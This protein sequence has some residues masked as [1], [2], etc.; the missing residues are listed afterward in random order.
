MTKPLKIQ[1][2]DT[3][4]KQ[5]GDHVPWESDKPL[6][7]LLK[8]V[9]SGLVKGKDALDIGCGTGNQSIYLAQQGFKVTAIDWS[10]QALRVAKNKNVKPQL[11]IRFIE[12]DI[13]KLSQLLPAEQFDL[14]VDYS[15]LHHIPEAQLKSYAHQCMNALKPGG[16]M[17]LACF[18]IGDE[19][20]SKEVSSGA[21][22]GHFNAVYQRPNKAILAAYDGLEKL[23]SYD[24]KL[25]DSIGHM[26]LFLLQKTFI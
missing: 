23:D 9:D 2:W 6:K 4:Y 25:A 8:L 14:I 11:P 10:Q 7:D 21:T 15:V 13:T 5:L 22:K 16:I 12:G 26:R 24:T 20:T 18:S 3:L 19:P 1:R 17:F